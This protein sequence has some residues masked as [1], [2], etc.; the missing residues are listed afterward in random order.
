M[1]KEKERN[2]REWIS[3]VSPASTFFSE[4]FFPLFRVIRDEMLFVRE[5]TIAV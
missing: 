3:S 1:E 4:A 5:G 2:N